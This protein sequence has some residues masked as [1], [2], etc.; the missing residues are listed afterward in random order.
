MNIPIDGSGLT[1]TAGQTYDYLIAT[2][3]DSVT[4]KSGP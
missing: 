3:G 2:S 1:F 4:S